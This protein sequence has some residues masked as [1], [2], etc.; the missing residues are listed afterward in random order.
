M[1][2][3][4]SS[5]TGVWGTAREL[6]DLAR[7]TLGRIDLDPFSDPTWNA[8]IGAERILT[9]RD[10]AFSCRW[11]G[12]DSFPS[13]ADILAGENDDDGNR[14]A[15][16]Y[17]SMRPRPSTAIV[18]GPG[19]PSGDAIKRAWR[20]TEW[21]HRAGFLGGG[22]IWIAFNVGQLQTLQN[23]GAPRSLLSFPLLIASSRVRYV[24]SPAT[25]AARHRQLAGVERSLRTATGRRAKLLR[26]QASRLA[27][28]ATAPPHAS[29][30]AL[31]PAHNPREA[32]RQRQ[33]F[34]LVGGRLGEVRL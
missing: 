16:L 21:H 33:I 34:A 29:A 12:S 8:T 28:G 10:D 24:E 1:K 32:D 25:A 14:P 26:A 31:L 5:A 4:H 9:E 23:A 7:A 19:D 27:A 20:L 11:F 2:A 13:A 30:V 18:N 22:C 6:V 3:Q 17:L 15:S